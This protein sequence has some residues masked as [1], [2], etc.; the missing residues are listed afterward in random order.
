MFVKENLNPRGKKTCDC[1]IRAIAKA[2]SMPYNTILDKLVE[3]SKK[4]GY[5]Y[6]DTKCYSKVIESLG[7]TKISLGKVT[8]GT[9]R[10]LVKD[11]AEK[12][13]NNFDCYLCTCSGHLTVVMNGNVYDIWDCSDRPV[14]SYY[15]RN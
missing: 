2:T 13:K 7:F 15:K 3:A 4:T 9:S 6:N 14:F 1:V 12:T 8:K 11:I 10:P 5:A